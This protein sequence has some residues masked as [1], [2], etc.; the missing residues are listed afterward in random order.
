MI[1]HRLI[2]TIPTFH[3]E[4]IRIHAT[5]INESFSHLHGVKMPKYRHEVKIYFTHS[6]SC[7][8][9]LGKVSFV[10]L[11]LWMRKFSFFLSLSFGKKVSNFCRK[12]ESFHLFIHAQ[13][14]I[15]IDQIEFLLNAN[16]MKF[17][18]CTKQF[19]MSYLCLFDQ[20]KWVSEWMS[21]RERRKKIFRKLHLKTF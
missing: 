10:V 8:Q 14:S 6:V 4:I 19:S 20:S 17:S 12:K 7:T 16:M 1:I 3:N 13:L 15:P 11:T 5:T 18:A 2:E 9:S 21:E